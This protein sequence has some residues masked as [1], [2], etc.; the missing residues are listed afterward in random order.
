M[1]T[2]VIAEHLAAGNA[3]A[4]RRRSGLQRWLAGWAA[5]GI[6][7]SGATQLR[8]G[9]G[10][11]PLGP[12]EVIL[13]CWMFF[14]IFLLLRG[15]PFKP[16]DAF[17]G[18]VVYWLLAWILLGLGALISLHT[19][20][21]SGEAGHDT[22][23]FLYVSVL[24]LLLSLNIGDRQGSDFHWYL[25][26][27]F[28]LFNATSAGLLMAIATVTPGLG[29]IDFWLGPRLR[30][31]ADNPNQLGLAMAAMPFLGWLVLQR[32]SGLFGKI[33]CALGIAVSVVAGFAT[34][35]DGLR[36]AWVASFGAVSAMLFFRVTLRGRSRWLLISH[37][38]IPA[39]F[40]IVGV[41]YGE[42]VVE[43]LDEISEGV[44]AEGGQGDT[45]LTAWRNGFEAMSKSPLLGF[46][47]GAYSGLFGPFENVEAHNSMIDW[48][49][50]TGLI[51]VLLHL[52]LWGWC[53]WRSLQFKSTSILGMMVA[54]VVCVT[55]SYFLRHPSYWIVL[56]LVLALTEARSETNGRR[57]VPPASGG[58]SQ[59]LG[60]APRTL[61]PGL[62]IRMNTR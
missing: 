47:P 46:G 58:V 28:F 39:A 41:F 43:K 10:G 51:G 21:I 37:A 23:A 13:G 60:E 31:W 17:L 5:F 42:A 4:V 45:R 36:A 40:V 30:G 19:H 33:G 52:T 38:A 22:I 20:R 56:L 9:G 1:S 11:V 26:R 53:F 3:A 16:G 29:Q 15:V 18:L 57:A 44:Y 48:G 27:T 62:A 35:S 32:T 54:L 12:S 24:F 49:M 14:V 6:T 59:S 25:A 8:I 50:S 55:F 34:Q 61:R 7:L 2:Q